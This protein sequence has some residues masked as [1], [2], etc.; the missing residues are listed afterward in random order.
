M[1]N[2]CIIKLYISSITNTIIIIAIIKSTY[3]ERMVY[4]RGI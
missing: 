2:T 3:M 4:G 1:N